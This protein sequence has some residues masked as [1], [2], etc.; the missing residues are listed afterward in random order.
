MIVFRNSNTFPEYQLSFRLFRPFLQEN[1]KL[2]ILIEMCASA[3]ARRCHYDQQS[4]GDNPD[5]RSKCDC[6]VI[7]NDFFVLTIEW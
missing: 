6:F 2:T 5:C 1:T 4:P 3:H 7:E